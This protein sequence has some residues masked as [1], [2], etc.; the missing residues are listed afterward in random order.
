ME[1]LAKLIGT[2]FVF[3]IVAAIAS[4]FLVGWWPFIA[5]AVAVYF[6]WS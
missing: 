3:F 1:F 2:P 4:I 6:V 5:G